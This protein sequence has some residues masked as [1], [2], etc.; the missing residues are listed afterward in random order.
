M[1]NVFRLGVLAARQMIKAGLAPGFRMPPLAPKPIPE[2][3]KGV[4]GVGGA[5]QW[6]KEP[7]LSDDALK[8][9]DPNV[10]ARWLDSHQ[11]KPTPP[12]GYDPTLSYGSGTLTPRQRSVG[13]IERDR[14]YRQDM[15]EYESIRQPGEYPTARIDPEYALTAAQRPA[16]YDRWLA[17]QSPK[18]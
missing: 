13:L 11:L 15:R 17:A 4:A 3:P 12:A 1:S 7:R 6:T 10:I 9:G 16:F 14:Q 18:R 8:N 2:A 5:V